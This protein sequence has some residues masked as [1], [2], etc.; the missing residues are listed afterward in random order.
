MKRF[1]L[2][3]LFSILFPLS[4]VYGQAPI[5]RG[6]IG[7]LLGRPAGEAVARDM[8]SNVAEDSWHTYLAK[9]TLDGYMIENERLLQEMYDSHSLIGSADHVRY[10]RWRSRTN[11][12]GE[13]LS[14]KITSFV[15][16]PQGSY[17]N[18][19]AYY[20]SFP[21]IWAQVE[22]VLHGLGV[23]EG[24]LDGAYGFR[25]I[26]E[27]HFV[28]TLNEVFF[29]MSTP[30]ER[31]VSASE[32]LEQGLQQA[33]EQKSGF[34]AIS[35]AGNNRRPKDVLLLD[36]NRKEFISLLKTRG[37]LWQREDARLANGVQTDE[38]EALTNGI[39]DKRE[40]SGVM[41]SMRS[42]AKM[43]KQPDWR[44]I[45]YRA[46]ERAEDLPCALDSFFSVMISTDGKNWAVFSMDSNEGKQIYRAFSKGY[47]I[48][49]KEAEGSEPLAFEETPEGIVFYEPKDFVLSFAS[50]KGRPLYSDLKKAEQDSY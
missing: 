12:L 32:A 43:R 23:F 31:G 1:F 19:P 14:R 33:L 48:Y 20:P 39:F 28:P 36:L 37:A 5:M 45:S 13:D 46:P 3:S 11:F 49:Y 34:F 30:V 16:K 38:M 50:A 2:L 6:I 27:A 17:E 10:S 24:I 25:P 29:L 40:K 21:K 22:P 47:Y 41:L 9:N 4:Q 26:F 44:G 18:F 15:T 42:V 35:V 8:V 7:G